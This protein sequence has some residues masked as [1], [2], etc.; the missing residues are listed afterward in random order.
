MFRHWGMFLLRVVR[1]WNSLYKV[2]D[3]PFLMVF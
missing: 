2:V 3:A 1:C